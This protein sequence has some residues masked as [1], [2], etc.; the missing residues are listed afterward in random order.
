MGQDAN[1][2]PWTESNIPIPSIEVEVFCTD[3]LL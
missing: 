1:G 2:N 3:Q